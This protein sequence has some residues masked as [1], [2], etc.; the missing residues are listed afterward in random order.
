MTA[1]SESATDVV[2]CD[3]C[4]LP[5]P[6]ALVD[7]TG[8][9]QFCCHGCRTVYTLL[10]DAGLDQYY[11][12]RNEFDPDAAHPVGE[13][14]DEAT[15]AYAV[16][17]AP[18]FASRYV[19]HESDHRAHVDLHLQN[20]RCAACLWLIERLP[21]LD[22]AVIESRLSLRRGVARVTWDPTV[23]PLSR[24]ARTLDRL[25][26]PARPA[27]GSA[28]EHAAARREEER[29]QWVRIG[30]AG[31][32]AGNTMLLAFALYAGVFDGME[33]GFVALF[34]WLSAAIGGVA[35]FGPGLV[36]F[37]GAWAALRS[38]SANLDLPIAL[39]LGV[40]GVAGLT[41]TVT[42]RGDLYF[43]SLSVLVFLLLVGRY[44]QYRQQRWADDTVGLL[45]SLTPVSCRRVR[46]NGATEDIPIE[47]LQPGD[48]VE[49]RPG[50]LLPA[51]GEVTYGRSSVEQALLTGEAAAVGVGVG[52][53]V[54]AG[55]K[56]SADTL[57][58][59]VTR[60][61][62]DTRVGRLM[63]LVQDGVEHKPAI[64]QLTDRIA[65]R[66]VVAVS[67][68]A[69]LVFAGWWAFGGALGAAVNHT[70]ALLIVACPC[71]LALATPL[72]LAVACGRAARRDI[73]IKR[74]AA[75]EL[76]TH[77]GTLYLDKTGT[78]THGHTALVGWFGPAWL[79]GVVAEL[80]AE[81]T[82]PVGRALATLFGDTEPNATDRRELHERIERGDGGVEARLDQQ[83]LLV[84]SPRFLQRHGVTFDAG[85]LCRIT[86]HESAG[87]TVVLV[88]LNG[89][90]VALAALGDRVRDDALRAVRSCRDH[91]W[92]PTLLS[93]DAPRVVRHVAGQLGIDETNATGGVLPEAKLDTIRDT[94]GPTVMVGDGV[95]DAAAL[96][97]ADLGIAVRGGAE[98]SLAAADV[99]LAR[100]G[101]AALP[102][103]FAVAQRAMRLIRINLAV[104]LSYNAT[105][106]GLAAAGLV[107]PLLAAVIM[108]ISSAVALAI[109][110]A[111]H[112]SFRNNA[113]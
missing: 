78:V 10:H 63:R 106:V 38:R 24:I 97:A 45:L 69:L 89:E 16:F 103:L 13:T 40:G 21:R 58:I 53:D 11:R 8:S 3:H 39:A 76:L 42:G 85:W 51:D 77:G 66:F 4:G 107:T 18:A 98:A 110:V 61:G 62:E 20:V 22:R 79:R 52:D 113:N 105:A 35:L 82:H 104:S 28:A 23:S 25:G 75:L 112:G 44:V 70:V 33:A 91:G 86:A 90:P 56:N 81:S 99:Y 34:R 73:L 49:V 74:A 60:A 59:G 43:D 15:S 57:H 27:K 41:N 65:G 1:T 46:E 94:A 102:E 30:L 47:A 71:A 29:K 5:V 67:T 96:A 68:A 17:D 55:T 84:G 12:L 26:Y 14:T 48:T 2:A 109:A 32:C 9:H 95:N 108:P 64:V 92:T 88:S 37:R 6:S 83:P 111:G 36:F 7:T 54:F 100:D 80:E 31:A 19:E 101:L 72:T 50:E 87:R 93:G